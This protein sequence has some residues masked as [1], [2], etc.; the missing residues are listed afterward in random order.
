MLRFRYDWI[1]GAFAVRTPSADGPVTFPMSMS[2]QP[3]RV[4]PAPPLIPPPPRPGGPP[5]SRIQLDSSLR[6]W[7]E[8]NLGLW[9]SRRTYFLSEDEVV[10]VDMLLRVERFS[11]PVQG[12][13][14]YRFS[15]WP[16]QDNDFFD[17][18]PDYPRQGSMEAYL[19]GHQ[20][21]RSQSFFSATPS[22]SQI[23]QVDEHEL[24]FGSH[25]NDRHILEHIRL[26]DQDRFRARS[27]FSWRDGA[28]QL[29]E[30]HHEIRLEAAG[31]PLAGWP[32]SEPAPPAEL[33]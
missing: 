6:R 13:A 30:N 28:L 24:V 33:P 18:K 11:E 31:K 8:R 25:Y 7:F 4:S 12:E 10:R 15:W 21:C 26:V 16:E 23:R 1:P 9:R 32:E 27:I 22:S 17:R 29:S 14:A 19:C 3:D 20:L 5:R 2:I